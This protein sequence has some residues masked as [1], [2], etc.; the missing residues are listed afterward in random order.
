MNCVQDIDCGNL[1][2]VG[3]RGIEGC[4]NSLSG[5]NINDLYGINLKMG[6]AVAPQEYEGGVQLFREKIKFATKLVKSEFKKTIASKFRFD[7]Q[8]EDANSCEYTKGIFFWPLT[9]VKRGLVIRR[10][11]TRLAKIHIRRLFVRTKNGGNTILFINDGNT[12][13]TYEISLIAGLNTLNLDQTFEND[14]IFITIDNTS[15]EM[16]QGIC[17]EPCA[18]CSGHRK[19]YHMRVYGWDGANANEY[20]YGINVEGSLICDEDEL[21]CNVLD[22]M[23]FPIL[24]QSAVQVLGEKLNG[25]RL[26]NFT[27]FNAERAQELFDLYTKKYNSE[28][29]SCTKSLDHYL[30]NISDLCLTCKGNRYDTVLP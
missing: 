4:G 22:Q 25:P 11:D 15:F 2:V 12:E 21:F 3:I 29:K 17:D 7:S 14:E 23:Y 28:M 19:S 8:I 9:P 1:I 26:N 5:L 13:Y 24:Y 30:K 6:A 18:T 20:V 10:V 27:L 16:S